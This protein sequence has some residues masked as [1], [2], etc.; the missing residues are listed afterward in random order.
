MGI[1]LEDV[2]YRDHL[3]LEEFGWGFGGYRGRSWFAC[4]HPDLTEHRVWA[5]SRDVGLVVFDIAGQNLKLPRCTKVKCVAFF[6]FVHHDMLGRQL[7]RF[8]DRGKTALSF[9]I[10]EAKD[11]RMLQEAGYDGLIQ[12]GARL[13]DLDARCQSIGESVSERRTRDTSEPVSVW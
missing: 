1:V 9:A 6:A 8:R 12:V 10:Q 11:L 2:E 5:Q 13:P 7:D 4:E 3:E